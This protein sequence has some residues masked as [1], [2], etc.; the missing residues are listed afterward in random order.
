MYK[1]IDIATCNRKK[2]FNW[3]HTFSNPCY[4]ITI[5]LDVTNVVHFSKETKTSFFIN[6]LYIIMKSLNSVD[7]LRLRYVNGE[8][9]Q[10]DCIH[11]T[12]TVMT[13]ASVFENCKNKMEE[14]YSHFYQNCHQTI[15]QTKHQ[16][17][18]DDGYNDNQNY[19]VYYIT[20][21]PW[22][23]YTAMT[24]PIPANDK[25]SCSV[26]RICFGKYEEKNGRMILS[27]NLTVSHALVDGYPCCKALNQLK[28]NCIN[29]RD[30]LK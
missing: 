28:E 8:V 19:D 26:P 23:S 3:F 4:G 25:E 6:F 10:Y 11:P 7:E 5:D 13:D 24:H 15:E 12:Y 20:C 22:L 2:Q 1:I 17:S 16:N 30:F 21:L 14:N 27:F 9:R 29:A 18:V